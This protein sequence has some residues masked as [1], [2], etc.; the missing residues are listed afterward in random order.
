[1]TDLK[2]AAQQALEALESGLDVDPIFAGETI[3][4]LKAALEQPEQCMAHGEC[5]GGQCIYTS[6]SGQPEQDTDCHAQGICQ[7]SG[8]SIGQP[9]Q[10]PDRWGAGYEAGYAAGMAEMKQ[11]PVAWLDAERYRWLR[12]AGAWES[13]IGLEILSKEPYKFDAAVD[14]ARNKT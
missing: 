8:Y 13:E 3:T 9:E 6:Q 1:M 4:A 7:R 10:E 14:A 11:E 12:T 5:F 2:K